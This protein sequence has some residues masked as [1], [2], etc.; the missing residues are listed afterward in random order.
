MRTQDSGLAISDLE[1]PSDR[2]HRTE[3]RPSQS[4]CVHTYRSVEAVL[5]DSR[6]A[7]RRTRPTKK[8]DRKA[9]RQ[10]DRDDRRLTGI[11]RQ[12]GKSRGR[13]ARAFEEECPIQSTESEPK[14]VRIADLGPQ[15]TVAPP[16]GRSADGPVRRTSAG[17]SVWLNFGG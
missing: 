7:A 8:R 12:P 16:N 4:A 6:R 10:L 11:E 1:I 14:R 15:P 3:D 9:D 17:R 2:G 5:T 13:G